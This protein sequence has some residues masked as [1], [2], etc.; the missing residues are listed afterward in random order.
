MEGGRIKQRCRDER[1]QD[2]QQ[3]HYITTECCYNSGGRLGRTTNPNPT[4]NPNP[5]K[6][7]KKETEKKTLGG[8]FV[9]TQK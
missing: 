2:A 5:T 6:K 1:G 7:K 8:M 9:H 4:R 3:A